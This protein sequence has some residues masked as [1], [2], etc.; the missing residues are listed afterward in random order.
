MDTKKYIVE[1]GDTLDEILKKF[2]YPFWLVR[3]Q[4]E[5]NKLSD[6]LTIGQ[7]IKLPVLEALNQ[8]D[9]ETPISLQEE[10]NL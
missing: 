4:Q 9:N 10:S 5:E 8:G 1:K 6:K 2:E 3:R 7:V